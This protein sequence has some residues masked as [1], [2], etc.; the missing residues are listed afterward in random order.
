[1]GGVNI[2]YLTEIQRENSGTGGDGREEQVER[3]GR[4]RTA[5]VFLG[6]I[7][8]DKEIA[9]FGRNLLASGKVDVD[10]IF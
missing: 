9:Y 3:F 8:M 1:M 2:T 4:R 5:A 7:G 6:L 10:R